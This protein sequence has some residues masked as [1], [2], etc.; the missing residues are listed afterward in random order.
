MELN[1]KLYLV[2]DNNDKFMGIGVLW[3]LETIDESVSLREAA[4]KMNLSYS[5]AYGMLTRLEKEL[6]RPIVER[7]KGGQMREGVQLTAFACDF[8]AL[9]RK[10]QDKV[11]AEAQNCFVDFLDDFHKLEVNYG[12]KEGI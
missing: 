6:G 2:D 3:L 4:K 8:I 9:Y 7:R 11:K 5:K 10:F 1:T 12:N